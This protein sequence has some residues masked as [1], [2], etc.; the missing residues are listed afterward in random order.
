MERLVF[1]NDNNSVKDFK[2][3]VKSNIYVGDYRLHH[4]MLYNSV[5]GSVITPPASGCP[6]N[7]YVVR[8]RQKKTMLRADQSWFSVCHH[9]SGAEWEAGG[10][11]SHRLRQ[12]PHTRLKENLHPHV[13][14]IA[15]V[16]SRC[17]SVHVTSVVSIVVVRK[18]QK[19]ISNLI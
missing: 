2:C 7:F 17:V 13:F 5:T 9:I 6:F 10:N 14:I 1:Y 12:E 15:Q 3:C 4:N 16:Q 18:M 19:C 8:Q 11:W